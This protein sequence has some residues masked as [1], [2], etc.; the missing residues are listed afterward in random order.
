MGRISGLEMS[1]TH[2]RKKFSYLKT[3]AHAEIVFLYELPIQ[4]FHE[5]IVAIFSKKKSNFSLL[6]QRQF[7]DFFYRYGNLSMANAYTN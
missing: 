2:G 3:T 7:Y 1:S 4:K 5:V 6:L